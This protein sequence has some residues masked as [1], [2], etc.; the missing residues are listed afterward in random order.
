MGNVLRPL[1]V[2][3]APDDVEGSVLLQ[4][5]HNGGLV[6]VAAVENGVC[7]FQVLHH[8]GA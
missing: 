1:L 8:L 4:L 5:L 7:G 2:V 6:D 3:V